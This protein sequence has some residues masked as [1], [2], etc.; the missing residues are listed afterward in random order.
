M[1]TKNPS[2]PIPIPIQGQRA[3]LD[4]KDV[5]LGAAGVLQNWICREG[6]FQV[7]PGYRKSGTSL[8]D[9]PTRMI[10]YYNIKGEYSTVVGTLAHWYLW[11]LSTLDWTD[12]TDPTNPLH[13]IDLITTQRFRTF[14][15]DT[16]P[17]NYLVGVNGW[18]DV[19]KKW[20]GVSAYYE[21]V[22]GSPPLAK[23]IAVSF[24]RMLLG[25]YKDGLVEYPL[26]ITVSALNDFESGW[27]STQTVNL[28]DTNG[29]IIAMREMGPNLPIYKQ[30]AIY[31]ATGQAATDPFAFTLYYTGISGPVNGP[32]IVSLPNLH[33]FLGSD[34]MVYMF[35]GVTLSPI[36]QAAQYHIQNTWDSAKSDQAFGFYDSRRQEV[37]FFYPDLDHDWPNQGIM[38]NR[39]NGTVWPFKFDQL[40]LT[41]GMQLKTELNITIAQMTQ[42]LSTYTE[43]LG[44]LGYVRDTL[45]LG[46]YDGQIIEE[47]GNGDDD[48][49]IPFDMELGLVSPDPQGRDYFTVIESEHLFP[50]ATASQLVYITL[51]YSD[52]GEEPVDE[53]LGAGEIDIGNPGPYV[54]GHAETSRM[55]TMKMAG[56]ATEEVQWRG[57]FLSG[58][59]R[60]GR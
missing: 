54:L 7:R 29:P 41:C 48:Q 34:G 1:A 6:K 4:R 9:I 27:L 2:I 33:L 58:V 38:I 59:K 32:A 46:N 23:T 28:M 37:Y 11:N 55:F 5:P 10:T 20:D 25:N 16:P 26:G 14:M 43:A 3:D 12:I 36:S 35:D 47:S 13:G 42:P 57:S 15:K 31:V 21:D 24:N 22:A 40:M 60:G 53:A 49:P 56:E 30:D 44:T 8:A 50:R 19:P 17:V 45:W 18:T 52:S 39:T 51:G